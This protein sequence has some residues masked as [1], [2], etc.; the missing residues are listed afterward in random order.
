[1]FLSVDAAISSLYRL[2]VRL[3]QSFYSFAMTR[4][5]S[6]MNGYFGK[7]LFLITFSFNFVGIPQRLNQG[8]VKRLLFLTV[9]FKIKKASLKKEAFFVYVDCD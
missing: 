3:P 5:Y 1:V 9:L 6:G 8:R 4:F 7:L 2:F